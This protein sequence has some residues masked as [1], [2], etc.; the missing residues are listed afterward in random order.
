MTGPVFLYFMG[1]KLGEILGSLTHFERWLWA[2]SV[3]VVAGS[4]IVADQSDWL[5]LASSLVG[6]TSLIFIAK[7]MVIGQVLVILFSLGYGVVSYL[8][9]YYGEVITYLCMTAP[10]AVVALISWLRHPYKDSGEVEVA[11]VRPWQ[12]LLLLV[13]SLVVTTIFYHILGR[14]GTANLLVSTLSVAT[15]FVAVGLTALR[16]PY[17]A[18]GYA[19]NDIVLIVLWLLV[20]NYAMALCFLMFLANDIYGFVNWRRM[21]TRQKG[22]GVRKM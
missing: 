8:N 1:K 16:S 17:Y 15:S 19:F 18:V 20:S 5:T 12:L 6:V 7:G 14:L 21:R 3:T 2:V 9:D 10:M 13:L 4:Y 22:E 11:G